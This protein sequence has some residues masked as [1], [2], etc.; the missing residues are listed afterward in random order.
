MLPAISRAILSRWQPQ[1]VNPSLRLHQALYLRR[2][3]LGKECRYLS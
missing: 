2:A 1:G 3:V